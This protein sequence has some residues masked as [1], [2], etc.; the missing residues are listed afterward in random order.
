MPTYDSGFQRNNVAM[1]PDIYL[2]VRKQKRVTTNSSRFNAVRIVEVVVQ[3]WQVKMATGRSSVWLSL[4]VVSSKKTQGASKKGH[5]ITAQMCSRG[6]ST[7][8][9]D[10]GVENNSVSTMISNIESMG[11]DVCG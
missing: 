11:E 4:S 1:L 7:M 2:R 3:N 5:D 10:S 9:L 8:F 6:N